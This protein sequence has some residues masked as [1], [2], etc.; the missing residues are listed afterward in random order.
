[1]LDAAG[2][3]IDEAEV[4]RIPLSHSGDA[5][6]YIP[7]AQAGWAALQLA[8]QKLVLSAIKPAL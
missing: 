2:R 8:D 4:V 5:F 7:Q 6:L 3:K 1:V